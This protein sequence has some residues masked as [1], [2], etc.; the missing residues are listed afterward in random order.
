MPVLGDV[1]LVG[2]KIVDVDRYE[3]EPEEEA[4]GLPD[5]P[6]RGIDDVGDVLLD[7]FLDGGKIGFQ[8]GLNF[9]AALFIMRLGSLEPGGGSRVVSA[10]GALA[11][12]STRVS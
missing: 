7:G 3:P 1:V 11:E 12:G 6:Q 9:L 8:P 4:E 2:E 5:R 10:G